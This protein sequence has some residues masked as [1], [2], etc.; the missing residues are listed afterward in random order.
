MAVSFFT[1]TNRFAMVLRSE[2][3][4]SLRSFLEPPDAIT[5]GAIEAD[6]LMSLAGVAA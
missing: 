6:G 2:V 5:G 1:A 3:I 4:F